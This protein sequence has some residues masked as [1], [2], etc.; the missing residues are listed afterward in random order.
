MR[1]YINHFVFYFIFGIN[2]EAA[3]INISQT[4]AFFYVCFYRRHE[5]FMNGG[6]DLRKLQNHIVKSQNINFLHTKL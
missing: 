2:L 4:M 5:R 1:Q 3:C 6:C